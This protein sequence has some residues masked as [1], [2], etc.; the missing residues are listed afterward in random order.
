MKGGLFYK[1]RNKRQAKE[2]KPDPCSVGYNIIKVEI[3]VS[4]LRVVKRLNR[5]GAKFAKGFVFLLIGLTINEKKPCPYGQIYFI[6]LI[7]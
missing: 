7:R 4:D 3:P 2:K 1:T 5:K 6:F